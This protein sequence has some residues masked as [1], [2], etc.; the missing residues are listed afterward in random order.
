[1]VTGVY[2]ELL[3]HPPLELHLLSSPWHVKYCLAFMCCSCGSNLGQSEHR[4]I[5]A[6]RKRS[7]IALSKTTSFDPPPS[8]TVGV[9]A[10]T[11]RSEGTEA[12]ARCWHQAHR[13]LAGFLH[14]F[15][16]VHINPEPQCPL[17]F[18]L[19]ILFLNPSIYT[20]WAA[21]SFLMYQFYTSVNSWMSVDLLLAYSHP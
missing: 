7:G 2:I 18:Q 8:F 13:S 3:S 4:K 5:C 15:L 20:F 10:G 14:A 12:K 19:L 6:C 9:S 1:M 16:P 21:V 11:G 17:S